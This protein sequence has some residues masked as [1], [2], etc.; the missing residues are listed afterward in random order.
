[1]KRQGYLIVQVP[2]RF[3]R[4]YE[5]SSLPKHFQTYLAELR[6]E[7]AEFDSQKYKGISRN[8]FEADPYPSSTQHEL[9]ELAAAGIDVDKDKKAR[10]RM[11]EIQLN[12]ITADLLSDL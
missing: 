10:E 11:F 12:K 5:N 2:E 7:F 8:P 6:R 1:M 4:E 9:K 3:I